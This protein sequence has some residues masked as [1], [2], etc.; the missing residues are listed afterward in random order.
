MAE[1]FTIV[2]VNEIFV[3]QF[4]SVLWSLAMATFTTWVNI[5]STEYLYNKMTRLSE[6]QCRLYDRYWIQWGEGHCAEGE[7]GKITLYNV[8]FIWFIVVYN[9]HIILIH[10]SATGSVGA[11]RNQYLWGWQH[12]SMLH[13]YCWFS[14]VLQ[15]SSW[16]SREG[17]QTS[18]QYV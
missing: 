18:N 14:S 3:P 1:I 4:C 11:S 10:H 17:R 5:Y 2:V 7:H 12:T 13:P 8:L 6:F 15:H 9:A 16:C